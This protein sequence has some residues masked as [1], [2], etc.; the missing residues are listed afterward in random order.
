MSGGFAIVQPNSLMSINAVEGFPLE[1]FSADA[2]KAQIAEAQKV[3]SGS[4][5]EQDIAEAKIELE[6]SLQLMARQYQMRRADMRFVLLGAGESAGCSEIDFCRRHAHPV[7]VVYSGHQN[8]AFMFVLSSSTLRPL[9]CSV[10][11][12]SYP[13]LPAGHLMRKFI[14]LRYAR[15]EE[16]APSITRGIAPSNPRPGAFP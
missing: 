10:P 16:G 5:S 3:A 9:S 6:V 8:A 15:A 11:R 12:M 1:D 2:V 14:L 7:P 4:G 13:S